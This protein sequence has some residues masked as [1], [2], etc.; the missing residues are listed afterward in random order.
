MRIAEGLG[1][2]SRIAQGQGEPKRYPDLFDDIVADGAKHYGITVKQMK[3][4]LRSSDIKLMSKILAV[5]AVAEIC[6]E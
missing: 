1:A 6:R 2:A 4:R 5:P 3:K